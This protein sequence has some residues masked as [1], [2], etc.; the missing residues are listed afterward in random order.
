[1]KSRFLGEQRT[2]REKEKLRNEKLEEAKKRKI[3]AEL[4]AQKRDEHKGEEVR[5]TLQKKGII[6]RSSR[7]NLTESE[8]NSPRYGCQRSLTD[9]NAA[10]KPRSI[11]ELKRLTQAETDVLMNRPTIQSKGDRQWLLEQCRR[12]ESLQ[13]Q[14]IIA[15]VAALA[16][17]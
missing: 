10:R 14:E 9:L 1:L 6:P 12:R 13:F 2:K 7:F 5:R 16:Q 15:K 3:Q 17:T 8:G 4:E 11:L